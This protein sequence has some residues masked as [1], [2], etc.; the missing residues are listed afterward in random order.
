VT[1]SVVASA[2][3]YVAYAL[4]MGTILTAL[5]IAAAVSRRGLALAL[6]RVVPYVHRASGALLFLAGAYVVY[7]WA[8][9]LLPGSM[10]RTSGRSV[11]ERGELISSRAA[12]WLASETGKTVATIALLGLALLAIWALSRMLRAKRLE[13]DTGLVFA[14]RRRPASR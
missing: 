11:I 6:R 9:F 1:G 2:L 10:T 8:F 4:G 12:T 13:R 7:Y 5:A 14:H 3:S